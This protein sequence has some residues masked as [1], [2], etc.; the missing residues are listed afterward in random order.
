[1][2]ARSEHESFVLSSAVDDEE[3]EKG[4]GQ[5]GEGVRAGGEVGCCSGRKKKR[6]GQGERGI[7]EEF[8]FKKRKEEGFI[9]PYE[10]ETN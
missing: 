8:C 1:V 10:K 2:E 5:N 3:E 6:L 9:K 7:E 4:G